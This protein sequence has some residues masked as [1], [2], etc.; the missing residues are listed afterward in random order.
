MNVWKQ[1][2]EEKREARRKELREFYRQ[3]RNLRRA[4]EADVELANPNDL[5]VALAA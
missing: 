5:A 1:R 3:L 4:L 2:I